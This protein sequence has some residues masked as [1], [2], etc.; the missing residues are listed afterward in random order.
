MMAAVLWMGMAREWIQT[1]EPWRKISYFTYRMVDAKGKTARTA[2]L[3]V[4]RHGRRWTLTR[5][6]ANNWIHSV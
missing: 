1:P 5:L 3:R 4:L 2:V 6:V